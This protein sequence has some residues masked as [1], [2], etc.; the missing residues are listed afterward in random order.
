MSPELITA[1]RE[2]IEQSQSKEDI[3]SAVLAL[4]HSEEIFEAAYTLA[5]HDTK[6]TIIG[7]SDVAVALPTELPLVGALLKKAFAF[8]NSRFDL[9][10]FLALPLLISLTA[11][12]V[13]TRFP[14]SE[15]V[16]VLSDAVNYLA[17]FIYFICYMVCVYIVAYAGT[18]K[19]TYSEGIAFVRRIFIPLL[20]TYLCAGLLVLGGFMFFI[21][22]AIILSTYL[23]FTPFVLVFEDNKKG[24][25]AILSGR[26]LVVGRWWTVTLKMLG[27]MAVALLPVVML[28]GIY[29][30][31]VEAKKLNDWFTFAGDFAL[32]FFTAFTTVMSIHAANQLYHALKRTKNMVLE[33]K[34]LKIGYWLLILLGVSFIVLIIAAYILMPEKFKDM[35]KRYSEGTFVPSSTLQVQIS[36][37]QRVAEAFYQEHNQSYEGFCDSPA[38]TITDAETVA[39][40]D[41][42]GEWA[43]TASDSIDTW[44]AD[45]TTYAKRIKQPLEERTQCINLP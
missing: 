15:V 37:M 7:T 27:F 17:M 13:G 28:V 45:K 42:A 31:V 8:A 32:E 18:K 22:P 10:L 30:G 39:C 25:S 3:R 6:E 36:G 19:V 34:S 24:L 44:C 43:I 26:S 16:A 2:R 9:T 20:L 40:N 14:N 33:T 23:Y 38:T 4:G 41:D 29:E 5:L 35:E 1:I 12:E 21:I 11:V